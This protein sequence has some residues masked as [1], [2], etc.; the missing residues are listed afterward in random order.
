MKPQT[1]SQKLKSQARR[2]SI[3]E[4]MFATMQSAFGSH[5]ISPFAIAINM[6]S[7]LVAMLGSI[8]GLL[9]P[10]SQLF[11][12]RLIEKHPRKKIILKAVFLETIMWIP[13]V[14]IA[15]LFMNNIITNLLPLILLLTFALQIIF[16]NIAGPAWF[17]WMGDI[18]EE[19]SR[20][21][22]FSKRNLLTGFI[23][24]VLAITASFFLDFFKTQNWTMAGFVILF[25]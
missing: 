15:F 17:S 20:G 11:S 25:S 24:I 7:S 4:G 21:R 5:Y 23:A 16:A 2:H 22:Y 19:N 3:K 6:S 18:V 13:F 12:S 14:L 10:L 8:A 1:K 9:G